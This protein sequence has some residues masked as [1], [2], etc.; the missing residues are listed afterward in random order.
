LKPIPN[1]ELIIFDLDGT[2][3]N[4]I[5]DITDC[6]NHT[7][8]KF[9]GSLISYGAAQQ[10]VGGGTLK[11]IQKAFEHK[12]NDLDFIETAHAHFKE[13]YV[14]N[15]V[16]KT[17]PYNGVVEVL[18]FFK[19]KKKAVLS[20]KPHALTLEVIKGLKLDTCF[21]IVLGAN[22][23]LY[24]SKPHAAGVRHIMSLLSTA[25][26]KTLMLGDS[27]HDIHAGK[28]AGTYTCSV[29]YGYRERALLSK[30]QPDYIIDHI[31]ELKSILS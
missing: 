1:I 22:E 28:N 27:T 19:E 12:A 23:N 17:R 26:E 30:E 5:Y 15:L 8:A 2:L 11:L 25:P 13:R 7:L 29:T 6:L 31:R 9:G 20:N 4:S 24:R 18:E 3:V 14:K 21:D 16:V 10:L